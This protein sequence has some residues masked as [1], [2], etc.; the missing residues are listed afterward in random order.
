MVERRATMPYSLAEQSQQQFRRG[1]V[2]GIGAGFVIVRRQQVAVGLLGCGYVAFFPSVK[3][4]AVLGG[5]PMGGHADHSD[6]THRKERQ[7]QRI[8][9]AVNLKAGRSL[10]D[11]LR[12]LGWIACGVFHAHDV[13]GFVCQLQQNR[14]LHF[15]TCAHGDV[16]DDDGQIRGVRHRQEVLFQACL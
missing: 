3:H 6:S 8:V 10:S 7:G 14:R 1:R 2:G 5:C 15:A 13:F 16:I 12:C 9:S 11:E 4:L